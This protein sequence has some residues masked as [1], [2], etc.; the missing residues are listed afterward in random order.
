M[1]A[2]K[3]ISL[4]S[5][6]ADRVEDVPGRSAPI[7][8]RILVEQITPTPFNV[9][10]EFGSRDELAE[11]GESIRVRQLQPVVVVSRAQYLRVAP[12]HAE[13]VGTASHVLVN[14]ERRF[15]AARAVGLST[16]DAVIR[17]EIADTRAAFLD[18]VFSENLDRRQF[19]PIEEARAVERM[20][21][22]C[23]SATAAASTWRKSE[24]WI[25]QRR[26]LLKLVPALQQLVA[27]GEMPVRVARSIATLPASEQE[28]A[29]QQAQAQASGRDQVDDDPPPDQ[30]DDP[31]RVPAQR[32]PS[33]K[34][35]GKML[36][37][38]KAVHGA[39]AVAELLRDELD[40]DEAVT[41]LTAA[42]RGLSPQALA[43]VIA[44]L[45]TLQTS[46]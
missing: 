18:A 40:E 45:G 14:G 22:E 30:A 19:N 6:A 37:R 5:L 2:A 46:T 43:S 23:G 36:A 27:R 33:P 11:L 8:T 38:Y 9:R 15:R 7:M 13:H 26:A 41:F 42:A 25:S 1:A 10:T 32:A 16:L 28:A 29:W 17:D 44:Q 21:A 3:R 20:V 4:A 39:D 12:E 31:P 24:G 34:A 35:A